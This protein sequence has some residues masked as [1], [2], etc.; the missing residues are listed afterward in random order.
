MRK[1]FEKWSEVFKW[2]IAELE[3]QEYVSQGARSTDKVFTVCRIN[4]MVQSRD[5]AETTHF[6]ESVLAPYKK[7]R[8]KLDRFTLRRHGVRRNVSDAVFINTSN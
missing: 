6:G 7:I 3:Y 2:N 1:W 8:V 4:Q 5:E